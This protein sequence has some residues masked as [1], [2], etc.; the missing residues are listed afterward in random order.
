MTLLKINR[1]SIK[2][3]NTGLLLTFTSDRAVNM[4]GNPYFPTPVPTVLAIQ[5][6]AKTFRDADALALHVRSILNP[7]ARQTAYE[8][9]IQGHVGWIEYIELTPGLT[10]EKLLTT[11]YTPYAERTSATVPPPAG[12][13]SYKPGLNTGEIMLIATLYKQDSHKVLYNWKVSEDQGTTW[14]NMVTLGNSH[15]RKTSGLELFREYWFKVAYA[16]TAGEGETSEHVTVVLTQDS[17]ATTNLK[18]KTKNAE[19][20]SAA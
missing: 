19:L 3:L 1:Q 9:L 17:R 6:L 16:T 15:R 18:S 20:K 10:M 5:D 13:P 2:S 7:Q 12:K 4:T 11:G 8:A 14:Q